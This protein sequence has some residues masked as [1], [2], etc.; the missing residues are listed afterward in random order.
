MFYTFTL[1][2]II[3][4]GNVRD[5]INDGLGPPMTMLTIAELQIVIGCD[6][7][8]MIIQKICYEVAIYGRL[9][10]LTKCG[11]IIFTF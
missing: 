7:I 3:L 11:I 6:L 2:T 8:N 10:Q 4:L 9:R 1:K 5:D